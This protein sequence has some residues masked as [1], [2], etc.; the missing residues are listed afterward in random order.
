MI[1]KKDREG[2]VEIDH[3]QSPGLPQQFLGG[4]IDVREGKKWRGKTLTCSH[5]TSVRI[6]NPNRVRDRG[7]CYSCDHYIC[8]ECAIELKVNGGVCLS[9]ERRMNEDLERAQRGLPPLPWR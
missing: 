9:F 7:Y 4:F 3:T 6:A 5:C 2:E 8:D 1:L